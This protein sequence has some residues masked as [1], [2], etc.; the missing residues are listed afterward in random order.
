V[1]RR[2]AASKEIV[3]ASG[4]RS[5]ASGEGGFAL[6]S[7]TSIPSNRLYLAIRSARHSELLNPKPRQLLDRSSERFKALTR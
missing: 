5:A 1:L 3:S 2:E 4:S 7:P 6:T